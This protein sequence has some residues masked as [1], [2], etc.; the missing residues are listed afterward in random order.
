MDGMRTGPPR[1]RT[2]AIPL[3]VTENIGN[4]GKLRQPT[5]LKAWH[6]HGK[7]TRLTGWHNHHVLWRTHGGR[8]TTDN[9]VL[10]HPHCHRQVHSQALDVAL[11]RSARNV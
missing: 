9:R 4:L 1:S 7:I 10:L 5:M 3:W 8:D 11:S 2:L 6:T